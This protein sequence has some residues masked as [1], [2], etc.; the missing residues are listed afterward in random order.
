[1]LKLC[2]SLES[3]DRGHFYEKKKKLE[4]VI[5]HIRSRNMFVLTAGFLNISCT[6][7]AVARGR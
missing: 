4:L 7:S 3:D 1:M 5:L 2:E 6:L